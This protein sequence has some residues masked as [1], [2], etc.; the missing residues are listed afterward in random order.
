[1]SSFDFDDFFRRNWQGGYNLTLGSA[2]THDLHVGYQRYT[3]GEDLERKSNAWG[4]I[5]LIG[6]RSKCPSTTACS[7]QQIFFQ[8]RL[9]Q[10]TFGNTPV[11]A[12]HSELR[13]QNAEINDTIHVGNWTYNAGVLVGNDTFFGQGLKKDSSTISGF[14]SCPGCRYEMYDIPWRKLIQPRLGVTWAYNGEDTV[15]A[16]LA[17][18]NP[19]ASSL[20]RAASWD[21]NF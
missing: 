15:Y 9:E 10:A 19:A 13:S 4:N 1:A 5:T 6:G 2:I 12:I 7:G 8:A 20:P 17:R 21:R 16:S 18:Y 14:A 3:D 11:R